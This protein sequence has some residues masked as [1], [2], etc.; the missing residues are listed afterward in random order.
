MPFV[1]VVDCNYMVLVGPDSITSDI[2]LG[3][4]FVH[5]G[6]ANITH[7]TVDAFIDFDSDRFLD[8]LNSGPSSP[9]A[10]NLLWGPHTLPG[11]LSL[12]GQCTPPIQ[13]PC[14]RRNFKNYMRMISC[15]TYLSTMRC[16][17]NN[18]TMSITHFRVG[19]CDCVCFFAP[20]CIYSVVSLAAGR[21]GLACTLRIENRLTQGGSSPTGLTTFNLKKLSKIL[22]QISPSLLSLSLNSPFLF[23][24]RRLG[25]FTTSG[26]RH[27][28]LIK[29]LL[30]LSG[31][32][33]HPGPV[34]RSQAD[35]NNMPP[36]LETAAV[37]VMQPAATQSTAS[38]AHPNAITAP[39]ERPRRRPPFTQQSA[40]ALVAQPTT[41][42]AAQPA[43][44]GRGRPRNSNNDNKPIHKN[45]NDTASSSTANT[46]TSRT[47][48]TRPRG[49][50]PAPRDQ[51]GRTI[52]AATCKQT[53]VETNRMNN[54][55]KSNDNNMKIG[56]F[57]IRSAG[58]KA[59]M[60]HDMINTE[61]LDMLFL[62]ETWYSA[63]L[64]PAVVDD[65]PAGYNAIHVLRGDAD[66]SKKKGGGVSIIHRSHL[67]I[68]CIRPKRNYTSLECLIV[69]FILD[70]AR[71]NIACVYHPPHVVTASL[72]KVVAEEFDIFFGEICDL[73]GR[74]IVLGDFNCPG[75]SPTT[76]D[77]RLRDIAAM[78]D[79]TQGAVGPTRFSP[80]SDGKS[81]FLDLVFHPTR[82]NWLTDVRTL[83]HDPS[84]SDH[85]L[86]SL[87]VLEKVPKAEIRIT[88]TRC[89]K[90]LD[91][92]V[93]A[94]KLE[95]CS[96]ITRPS[97]DPDAFCQQLTSDVIGVLDD[98]AP[99]EKVTKRVGAHPA[100][101]LSEEAATAKRDRR[102][103][104]RRYIR[105]KSEENRLAYRVACK[106]ARVRIKASLVA[107]TRDL[108]NSAKGDPRRLWKCC[109]D[110]LHRASRASQVLKISPDAFNTFFI[111]KVELIRDKIT[112]SLESISCL[113]LLTPQVTDPVMTLFD[114]VSLQDVLRVISEIPSKSS[115]RDVI[116]TF[117]LKEMAHFFAPSILRLCN[118]SLSKGVFPAGLKTGCIT[119]LLKKP[120]LD[121]AD[122]SNYR[123][124]TSLSTLSKILER[125][126]QEQLRPVIV[127]SDHFPNRQSAYR[128]AHSTE[129]ALLMI[130]SDI[131]NAMD[132]GSATCL[133]SLDI[134]AAFDALDHGILLERA[135][136]LF[137]VSGD[138][139]VW[140]TSYLGGRTAVTCSDGALSS[141][142][143]LL[144][145]VPQ[146]STLGP[147][148]FALYVA[149]MGSLVEDLGV[150]F[151]QYADD[152]QLYI[153]LSPG[154]DNLGALTKCA[155]TVN[156]WF[157]RNYLMLNTNKTEAILFGTAA[158]LRTLSLHEC[159][160]FSGAEP[161]SFA[162]SIHLMGVTLDAELSMDTQ[163]GEVVNT[164]N[165][166]LRALRHIRASLTK[167]VANTIACSLVLTRIDY[168]N[169][170]LY[171]TSD[172]NK[173]RLQRIQNR[174]A[175]IVLR[176]GRTSSSAPL[177][178]ELHWL[179]VEHRII[180][181]I[182]SLTYTALTHQQPRY[183]ADLLIRESHARAHR[184]NEQNRLRVT[185]R[186]L[187][188]SRSSFTHSSPE[189]WNSI[190]NFC[191]ESE[192][193]FTFCRRFKTELFTSLLSSSPDLGR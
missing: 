178:H 150:T 154:A 96:F 112:K 42:V 3:F 47:S 109:N 66:K 110:L 120:G 49:R 93:F 107:Y 65:V 162:K 48:T 152:T 22:F 147:L 40:A 69:S 105:I 55:D 75:D 125:L 148:L 145:G 158:K 19:A 130:T 36:L 177:L 119:P 56:L 124:I 92:A 172:R 1:Y 129:S 141:P 6:L 166:H 90:R 18:F 27:A 58:K 155:D 185:H 100:Y 10:N 103:C 176:A 104:E 184:S 32:H 174:T 132:R 179:P 186:R 76:F 24:P 77:D 83:S 54:N 135:R 136:D 101:S 183:L 102:A 8:N 79:L 61:K 62:T 95:G 17:F 189:I 5:G 106:A 26:R 91:R 121:A 126:A 122:V 169:S 41:T 192:D 170:L 51:Y 98:L 13:L 37:T 108:I 46:S 70:H 175:R 82:C 63:D 153:A 182:G 140:L 23:P 64:P 72:P 7:F 133:L 59:P 87:G 156:A 89:I 52:R 143:P 159:V 73:K 74:N 157:L 193:R 142:L 85:A 168:C 180:H 191:K 99:I 167:E 12:W 2:S 78:H 30:L 50:P 134:S 88:Y 113:I 44:R 131:R 33:P 14:L 188:A 139:L 160:P 57:N 173:Q 181:K 20:P 16:C 81:S 151:H 67:Q 149:P 165:Y 115:S 38:V 15:S 164:C 114:V 25:I 127:G 117:L 116:P 31:I 60:V 137:G 97:D 94:A 53:T 128:A 118:L 163:V 43:Q 34:T 171:G 84:I 146:G 21:V 80:R 28:A 111:H 45:S 190:S 29:A 161:I 4:G 187:E 9:F 86:V 35:R 138:A 68:S 11:S 123:P 39:R 144:T 71:Y